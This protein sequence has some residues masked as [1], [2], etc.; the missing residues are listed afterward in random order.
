MK[1]SLQRWGN[2]TTNQL[3]AVEKALNSQTTINVNN[4]PD[5]LKPIAN[6]DGESTF[7][8]DIKAKLLKYST[9]SQRQVDA[10]LNAIER[11]NNKVNTYKLDLPT[12]GETIKIGRTKGQELKQKYKLK[13]NPILIDI[14]EIKAISPKAVYFAGKMT[15]KRGDI[16]MCCAKTLTDEFSMLTRMGKMC[17]NHMGVKYITDKTQAEE[18][19]VEYLKKVEEIGV[20]EFWIP[21][22]KILK[23]TGDSEVLLKMLDH[24]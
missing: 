16:C 19:R 8:K 20:M 24:K 11:E 21:K 10:A 23:W 9:L 7:V 4:L 17:A 13:F 1:D 3:S 15:I 14:T 2:L 12:P 18:F 22:S 6:Y 5:N